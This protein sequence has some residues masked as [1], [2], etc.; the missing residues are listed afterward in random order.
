MSILPKQFQSN[1]ARGFPPVM[2]Q[3]NV[4][5]SD[6]MT[7]K[8]S[9]V[10]IPCINGELSGGSETKTFLIN[11]NC[12]NWHVF[13]NETHLNYLLGNDVITHVEIS[14]LRVKVVM[15]LQSLQI[16][17]NIHERQDSIM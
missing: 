14:I 6:S 3:S 8:T 12:H 17:R 4:P 16:H 1:D 5:V 2:E 7:C 9:L 11:I 15:A 13:V 10:S